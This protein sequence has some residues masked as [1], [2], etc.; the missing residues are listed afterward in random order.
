M[1][2]ESKRMADLKSS[3]GFRSD[4]HHR[5]ASALC[6]CSKLI[7]IPPLLPATLKLS[8]EFSSTNVS[9]S[10]AKLPSNVM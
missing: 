1:G 8:N 2:T 4:T 9:P 7:N 10:K 6:T 3:P 5:V